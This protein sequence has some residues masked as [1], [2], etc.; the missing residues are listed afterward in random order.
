MQLLSIFLLSL[1]E[2]IGMGNGVELTFVGDAMQHGPQIQAAAKPNG[3]YDY[4]SC[5]NLIEP[6]IENADYAVVNLECPLA[7][8]PYAGYPHFSAP[9]E[10]AAQLKKSGFDLFLTSNN[11]CL[12]CGDRGLKRT[13]AELDKLTIPHIGT[14]VDEDTRD[15]ALPFVAKVKDLN[16]GFLDYTFGT[17]GIS[18]TGPVVVDYID[19]ARIASDIAELRKKSP[20]FICVCVHWGIEYK[21]LPNKAQKDLADFLV[22]N[23]VDLVIGSHPHVV[24]PMEVRYSEKYHKNVL[25]VYSLGNFISNQNGADSR[26]G[27]MVKVHLTKYADISMFIDAK[28]GLFFCQKPLGKGDNYK[29]IPANKESLVREDSKAAFKTFMGNAESLFKQY[30][31]AVPSFQI[32]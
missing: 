15:N 9:D 12:D 3:T 19:R 16:I 7:G 26:G 27:A 8:R 29:L 1:I 20:D 11:H 28:Y 31:R 32:Q 18:A 24:Q 4:S 25:V 22:D 13:I 30:N 6:D 2:L 21:S 23:G 17:N 5:F 14:Y 10:Y